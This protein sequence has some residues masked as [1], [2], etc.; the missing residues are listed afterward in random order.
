MA[1]EWL[2]SECCVESMMRAWFLFMVSCSKSCLAA[3]FRVSW[4][5]T[6]GWNFPKI[7]EMRKHNQLRCHKFS[8]QSYYYGKSWYK[9]LKWHL[10]VFHLFLYCPPS[11]KPRQRL[12]DIPGGWLGPGGSSC[13]PG[14]PWSCPP[15]ATMTPQVGPAQGQFLVRIVKIKYI[16]RISMRKF[17]SINLVPIYE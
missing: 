4:G 12:P 10:I 14:S 6:S 7:V 3:R 2:L 9:R 5:N 8:I 1:G 16:N 13:A 15:H 11:Q 17:I